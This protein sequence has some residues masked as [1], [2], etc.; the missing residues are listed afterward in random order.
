MNQFDYGYINDLGHFFIPRA[1]QN[2]S[3]IKCCQAGYITYV[4]LVECKVENDCI[5]LKHHK[6]ISDI[7]HSE[8]QKNNPE[9]I[10]TIDELGRVALLKEHMEKLRISPFDILISRLLDDNTIAIKKVMLN[11]A[12]FRFGPC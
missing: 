6:T 11:L 4:K 7:V 5:V 8:T 9:D 3:E 2:E 1:M 10:R 12:Q